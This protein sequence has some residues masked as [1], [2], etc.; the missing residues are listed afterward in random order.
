M[1]RKIQILKKPQASILTF[2]LWQQAE[3]QL[4]PIDKIVRIRCQEYFFMER[5][6]KYFKKLNLNQLSIT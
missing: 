2:L 3:S 6:A 4:E 5:N 1:Q